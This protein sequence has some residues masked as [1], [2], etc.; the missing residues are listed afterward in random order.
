MQAF[1][2]LVSGGYA[3]P[4]LPDGGT[5]EGRDGGRRLNQAIARSNSNAADLPRLAAPALGSAIGVDVLETLVVG[6]LLAGK[7]ADV[8]QLTG[9]VVA[10]L[11]RS[12]R[13][14][15]REGRPVT[16]PTDARQIVLD[17]I[18]GI[19]ERRLPVLRRLGVLEG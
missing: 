18:R 7:P 13:S 16:D 15:Q 2:L 10:I 8:D 11:G 9:D 12:G 14:V 4:M 3:H 5:A 17:A 19:M 1:T 6:E